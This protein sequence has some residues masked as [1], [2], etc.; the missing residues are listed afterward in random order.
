V[1]FRTIWHHYASHNLS[2]SGWWY[3]FPGEK[4]FSHLGISRGL[5]TPRCA[6]A[7]KGFRT[8][9]PYLIEVARLDPYAPVDRAVIPGH[10]ESGPFK[11]PKNAW[12]MI[13]DR[14]ELKNLRIHDLRTGS[15]L[16]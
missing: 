9:K 12:K 10:G 11:E 8:A 1:L 7:D 14:A 15:R 13:L 5:A 16:A 4:V 3:P 2:M 6:Y